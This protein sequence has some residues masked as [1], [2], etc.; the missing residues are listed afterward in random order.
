VKTLALLGNPNVGKTAVF[1]ALTGLS[2]STGN[3]PGVTIDRKSGHAL[4]AG[5]SVEIVDL[6]GTYSLAARSP[7]EQIVAD[8]LLGQ[9]AGQNPIDG[10]IIVVDASNIER[11]LFLV[12]QLIEMGKPAVIA[13]NMMDIAARRGIA[14]DADKLA[15]KLGI[16][17]APICAHRKKGVPALKEK[18]G[19]LIRG[20]CAAPSPQWS[21]PEQ[22][23]ESVT[24]LVA[25]LAGY[26]KEIGHTIVPQEAFR[27][28]VDYDGYAERRVTRSLGNG[29]SDRLNEFRRRAQ[30]NRAPLAVQEANIR[31]KWVREV[32]D[33]CVKR[34]VVRP[35]TR[36]EAIDDVLSHRV[37]GAVIFAAI[38]LLIFQ[39]IFSWSAPIMDLVDTTVSG[40]G[41][42]V[43]GLM[44]HGMLRSLV[45]D[46][47]VAGVGSVLVFLP[48]I[49]LLSLF[50][51]I[52]EDTGYMAR[53]AFLMDKSFS[54]CGLSGHSFIPLMTSF[55][56]AIPGVL[57]TRTIENKRNRFATILIAP[58]MSCSARLPVYVL[59]IT[60]FVPKNP[61]FGGIVNSQGLVLFLMYC[62]GIVVSVPI[63][64]LVKRFV[65]QGER[66]PFIL[67]MP[68]YKVPQ[69]GT[70][71]RKVTREGKEFILRAGTLILAVTVVIWALAYFPHSKRIADEFNAK[72][73]VAR[74]STSAAAELDPVLAQIDNDESAAYMRNSFLGRAGQLVE[75]VFRPMG[76]DWRIATAAIASFPAREI[77]VGTLGTLFNM[78]SDTDENSPGLVETLQGATWPDGRPLF[79][80]PVALSVMVFFALCCQCG[81]T[82]IVIK[83]ETKQW[84][85]PVIT[86]VYMTVLAYVAAVITYQSSALFS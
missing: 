36:S 73:D 53:A 58:L 40:V 52:L 80:L 21:F 34:P 48:Q 37:F 76:W 13:L 14:I 8:V 56:C 50:I 9:Q 74:A 22:H 39:A 25:D 35:R 12:S 45:V 6:P 59:M 83:R 19:G 55:A 57:A 32:L 82:L 60:A 31:Y 5:E 46:G 24:A 41:D 71:I 7:D 86:F 38:M 33:Q 77:I 42:Y 70:V 30:I 54:W 85:W 18:I 63:A 26:S 81:A 4:I 10:M 11:N 49:L 69:I 44:A 84:R 1:N 2:Q 15:T 72:R 51:A 27:I 43:G 78:G 17:V 65:F 29:F 66:P 16:P 75:P 67:E 64:Y 28:L 23:Q 62:I 79:T 20:K 47:V 68:S 3:Y 61:V